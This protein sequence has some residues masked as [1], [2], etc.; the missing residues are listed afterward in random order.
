MHQVAYRGGEGRVPL[1]RHYYEDDREW[2]PPDDVWPYSLPHRSHIREVLQR[3][4]DRAQREYGR[5]P[6]NSRSLEAFHRTM[7]PP[8]PHLTRGATD[9]YRRAPREI[10]VWQ[11]EDDEPPE[12]RRHPRTRETTPEYDRPIRRARRRHLRPAPPPEPEPPSSESPP[13][14]SESE[15]ESEESESDNEIQVIELP[16]EE[17]DYDRRQR[18]RHRSRHRL[19]SRDQYQSS[20]ER[21][22]YRRRTSSSDDEEEDQ[23]GRGRRQIV[24]PPVTPSRQMI[25]R[26]FES[27][28][29]KY[30]RDPSSRVTSV[31]E[32][33]RP[34][35]ASR[36]LAGELVLQSSP[37]DPRPRT[38]KVYDAQGVHYRE[39]RRGRSTSANTTLHQSRSSSRQP[40]SLRGSDY[41]ASSRMS[42]PERPTRL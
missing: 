41:E 28:S 32:S 26:R 31:I 6:R 23:Y 14:G 22:S 12:E 4:D 29:P 25:P 1:P 36:R 24:E 27:E 42:S 8:P 38:I 37:S 34:P 20:S 33:S 40:L 21:R 9:P 15:E 10:L 2:Q 30:D 3:P 39:A 35:V 11:D 19:P 5:A 7:Q 17:S 16:D 18:R 13:S